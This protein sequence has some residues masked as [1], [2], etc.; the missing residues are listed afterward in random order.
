MND[1]DYYYDK[2]LIHLSDE[3]NYSKYT[4]QVNKVSLSAFINWCRESGCNN[5]TDITKQILSDY[6]KYL[7]EYRKRNGD[8]LEISTRKNR[9][10]KLRSFFS[11]AYRNNFILY[12]PASDLELPKGESRLP[13]NV[14]SQREAEIIL[15]KPDTTTLI[16]IRDKAILETFY[17]TGVR[18][19]ELLNLTID[20][21]NFTRETLTVRKGKWG[22]DRVVPLG[23][24][25]L[26]WLERYL[27]EVCPYLVK[28]ISSSL[29]VKKS[30]KLFIG[31]WGEPLSGDRLGKIVA[32]YIRKAR[33]DKKASCH[34]FRHSMATHMLENGA[35]VR[36]VQQMLGHVSI[37]TTKIY[38]HVAIDKLKQVHRDTHP[39]EKKD[40]EII[41][42]SDRKRS[43]SK[44]PG[45]INL[46]KNKDYYKE[47]ETYKKK[48]DYKESSIFSLLERFLEDK[49]ARNYSLK[50]IG[51]YNYDLKIFIRWCNK[52]GIQ[53]ITEVSKELLNNYQSYINM[54]ENKQ[55]GEIISI[56]SRLNLLSSLRS[57]FIYLSENNYIIYN[58][59]ADIEIPRVPKSLPV[60]VL[61]ADEAEKILNHVDLKNPNGIRD[62][63]ILELLYATGMRRKEM[64]NLELSDL[65]LENNTLLIREGK[66]RKDRY[67][68]IGERSVIWIKRYL[69][70]RPECI[71]KEDYLFLTD[72]GKKM[73][74]GWLGY[75]VHCHVKNAGIGKSGSFLLFRHSV[76]T[77]MLENGADIRYIQQILGHVNLETTQIYTHVSI[78]KLKEVHERT[79]PSTKLRSTM[80]D[81]NS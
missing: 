59:A 65:D 3:K 45:N 51:N 7:S 38:T 4:I 73:K 47:K 27:K 20:D 53:N 74:G 24:R 2:Y 56:K 58:P 69:D 25:A 41:D 1:L 22:N 15:S 57:F 55:T 9:I 46:K 72:Y 30:V 54:L 67:I 12:N 60:D 35:D 17:S 26:Y 29:V 48:G 18:K 37:E 64:C 78:G 16:G 6:Q 21:V 28:K 40:N 44:K 8:I 52:T 34:I 36:Y 42:L 5:I 62:R 31:R 66:G 39:G 68:P 14:L 75:L 13:R 77:L 23:K 80:L 71:D 50:T 19:F 81:N 11:W 32:D 76:A 63:A 33:I 49:I 10:S 79:H 61:T 43:R 70:I